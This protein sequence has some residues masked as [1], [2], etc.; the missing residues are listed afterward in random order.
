[1]LRP[2]NKSQHKYIVALRQLA[3]C[4]PGG[5]ISL[6]AGGKLLQNIVPSDNTC[7]L[8]LNKNCDTINAHT[9]ENMPLYAFQDYLE[10]FM[11]TTGPNSEESAGFTMKQVHA[12]NQRVM[13]ASQKRDH[14]QFLMS[15]FYDRFIKHV[16]AFWLASLPLRHANGMPLAVLSI[17]RS[18]SESDFNHIEIQ[19]LE[20]AQPWLEHLALKDAMVVAANSLCISSGGESASASLL[21]DAAGKVISASAFALTLLHQAADTPLANN[22]LRQTAQGDVNILLRRLSR[23]VANAMNALSALPPSLV[24]NN[25]WGRFHLHAYVLNPF[26]TGTPMQISL[27]I[28]HQIPLSLGLFRLPRFLE[29]TPREREV[30]L[31]TLSGLDYKEIAHELG[32]KPS[33]VIYFTRQLYRRLNINKQSELLPALMQ[34]AVEA[35]RFAP[36]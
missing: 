24:L 31:H 15:T 27:H 2:A 29:L 9:F 7:I 16:H 3:L 17:G 34:D 23:S 5:D 30:C 21:F 35:Y 4:A 22:P 19:L 33:T 11:H 18:P 25:H 12:S 20:Q 14:N 10:N 13:L 32:V 8:W 1:M 36:R 28:E 6:I 26:E